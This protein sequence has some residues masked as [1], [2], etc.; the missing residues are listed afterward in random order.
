MAWYTVSS[1]SEV[2]G[3][4]GAEEGRDRRPKLS[5]WRPK[6]KAQLNGHER[7]SLPRHRATLGQSRSSACNNNDA[8]CEQLAR[9]PTRV[10]NALSPSPSILKPSIL[11]QSTKQLLLYAPTAVTPP[12]HTTTKY[13]QPLRHRQ[14]GRQKIRTR[15]PSGRR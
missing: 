12:A 8:T 7:L 14:Y 6:P 11:S 5:L 13:L 3:L 2:G 10:P 4:R 15:P 9:E 1:Q